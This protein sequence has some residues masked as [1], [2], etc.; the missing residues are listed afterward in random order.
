VARRVTR[1]S[2]RVS[3]AEQQ[4]REWEEEK[5]ALEARSRRS[6][7]QEARLREISSLIKSARL[8][9][10]R[11][12][13]AKRGFDEVAVQTAEKSL[14]TV[15]QRDDRRRNIIQLIS[16]TDITSRRMLQEALAERGFELSTQTLERDMR[17]LNLRYY[18]EPG[19]PRK[20]VVFDGGTD[21]QLDALEQI[22]FEFASRVSMSVEEVGQQGQMVFIHC[23]EKLAP[24]LIDTLRS[25]GRP[26]IISLL[27]D[28]SVIWCWCID[29][30]SAAKLAAIIQKHSLLGG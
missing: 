24:F 8:L 17:D 2:Q 21:N 9:Q 20:F 28:Q 15:A 12:T 1:L 13:E 18:K 30:E 6:V 7:P 29:E 23:T 14:V 10:G 25:M 26:D 4:V 27:N 22:D 11:L 3:Q 19:K 5:A 16:T